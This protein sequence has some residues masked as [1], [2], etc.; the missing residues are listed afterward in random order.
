ME[1][2]TLQQGL[3]KTSPARLIRQAV[4]V[5]EQGF[6]NEFDDTDDSAWHVVLSIDGEPAACGRTFPK[7]GCDGTYII[8][9]VAVLPPFRGRRAGRMLMG[10]LEAQAQKLGAQRIELSAQEQAMGF[11]Q[12]LGYQAVGDL[13]ND[14]HCPHM[15]MVKTLSGGE[16]DE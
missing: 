5:E 3:S 6:A 11:Y 15:L 8:G 16:A 13:Y 1:A 10:A 14:E 12:K 4:F 9:R 7:E 2:I